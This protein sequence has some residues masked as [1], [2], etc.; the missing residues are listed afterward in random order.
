MA[1]RWRA[2]DGPTLNADLKDLCV[3]QRIRTSMLRNAIFW[4]FFSGRGG[5]GG[6]G[7]D[8][9]PPPLDPRM[10]LFVMEI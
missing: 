8:P 4:W 9:L 6:G 10:N 5:G 1:F 3:F 7:P 2:D